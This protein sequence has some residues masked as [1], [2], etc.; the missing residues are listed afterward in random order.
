MLI[1]KLRNRI[2]LKRLVVIQFIL[3]LLIALFFFGV[4][5]KLLEPI[6]KSFTFSSLDIYDINSLT[7]GRFEVYKESFRFLAIHPFFGESM[8]CNR[9]F[10]IPHNYLIDKW[11]KFGII[12]SLPLTIFY[13]YL[14]VFF[15]RRLKTPSSYSFSELSLWLLLLSLI[16]SIFEYSSPYGP[17]VT[18][19]MVWFMLGQY[20]S[21]RYR[22]N[23][24][25]KQ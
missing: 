16:I 10:A 9:W 21:N 19:I 18:H 1:Y 6:W 11:V 3:L 24:G 15:F 25:V 8:S 17:G 7:S 14:W 12:G 2:M 22:V 4:L 13:A 5:E 23:I 20:I